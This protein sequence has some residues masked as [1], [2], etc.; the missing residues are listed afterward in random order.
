MSLKRG[1][2]REESVGT[3][4]QKDLRQ[5]RGHTMATTSG[6]TATPRM[7][8]DGG[9]DKEYW[10]K[11]ALEYKNLYQNVAPH[12]VSTA[13]TVTTGSSSVPVLVGKLTVG[14][15]RALKYHI[16]NEAWADV[17]FIPNLHVFKIN[18]ELAE[19]ARKGMGIKKEVHGDLYD[20][21]LM[22]RYKYEINQKRSNVK[23]A[24]RKKYRGECAGRN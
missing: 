23:T 4:G 17:K 7:E 9:G 13:S 1:Q 20:A 24:V 15:E 12:G 3:W 18:P 14:H 16:F 21:S 10:K 6:Q 8:P 2:D 5:H 19:E 22:A 11:E